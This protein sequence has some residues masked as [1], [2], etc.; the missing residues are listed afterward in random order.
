M[1]DIGVD[2]LIFVWFLL[3]KRLDYDWEFV[4]CFVIFVLFMLGLL[5][6]VVLVL[7]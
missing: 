3:F 2:G 6:V 4:M 5:I 1:G 7:V